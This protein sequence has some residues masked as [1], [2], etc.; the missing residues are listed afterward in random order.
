MGAGTLVA[1]PHARVP[2]TESVRASVL[3]GV[4]SKELDEEEPRPKS[5][6]P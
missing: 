6:A 5:C 2:A 3:T 1:V 4:R